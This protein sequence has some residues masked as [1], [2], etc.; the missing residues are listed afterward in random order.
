M[1]KVKFQGQDIAPSKVVCIGRNYVEH[2]AELANETPSEPVI[3]I[4]PNSAIT[5][6]IVLKGPQ[7]IHYEAEV[8]YLLCGGAVHGIG[9][10][11]DLTKRELQGQLK[12]K[13][14]PW[15]KAKAFDGSAVFSQFVPYCGDL[16]ELS[17]KFY[18]DNELRQTASFDQ[19]IFK[20]EVFLANIQSFMTLQDGDV[21]MTGT[22]SGVG[23]LYLGQELRGQ[24]FAGE[25]LLL[26]ANWSV[27]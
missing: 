20:P 26:E 14:L 4:K 25:T 15:E 9:F 2:I 12:S 18:I 8:C 11:L 16:A 7:A 27:A 1:N 17:M 3:F 21:V 6:S 19:M 22:P 24:I 5:D 23:P 13:G 10:G